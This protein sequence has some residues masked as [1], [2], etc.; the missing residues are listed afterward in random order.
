M[1]SNTELGATTKRIAESTCA[2]II[3]VVLQTQ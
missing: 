2:K 1:V 3:K